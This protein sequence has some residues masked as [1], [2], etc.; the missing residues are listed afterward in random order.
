MDAILIQFLLG[1]YFVG[2]SLPTLLESRTPESRT[3]R[4]AIVLFIEGV[5]LWVLAFLHISLI[6]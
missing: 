2:T 5:L 1:V 6:R 4:G 3:P